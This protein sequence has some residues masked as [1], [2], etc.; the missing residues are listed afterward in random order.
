MF[1]IGLVREYLTVILCE[2]ILSESLF[3]F[4][5]IVLFLFNLQNSALSVIKKGKKLDT[6]VAS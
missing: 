4:T 2:L 3:G 5:V 1:R 6:R